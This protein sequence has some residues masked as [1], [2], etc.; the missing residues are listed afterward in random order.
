MSFLLADVFLR[1]AC[2]LSPFGQIFFLHIC[3]FD[4]LSF[5]LSVSSDQV[6]FSIVTPSFPRSSVFSLPGDSGSEAT[7]S[8][9]TVFPSLAVQGKPPCSGSHKHTPSYAD[10][11]TGVHICAHSLFR[12]EQ[13][14]FPAFVEAGWP[15]VPPL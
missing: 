13:C 8:M 15:D 10:T 9:R 14:R 12:L 11:Q 5:C 3:D 7:H 6:V 1:I 2:L 4:T